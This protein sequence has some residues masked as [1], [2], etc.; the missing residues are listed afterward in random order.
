[1]SVCIRKNRQAHLSANPANRNNPYHFNNTT[2]TNHKKLY[3]SQRWTFHRIRNMYGSRDSY[4]SI[5][6]FPRFVYV[7]GKHDDGGKRDR[8]HT[9]TGYT[10]HWRR[11]EEKY[12]GIFLFNGYSYARLI[13]IVC[14]PFECVCLCVYVCVLPFIW[15]IAFIRFGFVQIVAYKYVDEC[16]CVCASCRTAAIYT[17]HRI[18]CGKFCHW[19]SSCHQRAVRGCC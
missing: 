9:H 11:D 15:G 7:H 4:T 10:R 18:D 16:V 13:L 8:T 17:I 14:V 6:V 12:R 2:P 3:R 5:Y 1:M 19:P